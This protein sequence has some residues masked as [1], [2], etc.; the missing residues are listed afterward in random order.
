MAHRQSEPR[1]DDGRDSEAMTPRFGGGSYDT[2]SYGGSYTDSFATH[3][4]SMSDDVGTPPGSGPAGNTGAVAGSGA[5]PYSAFSDAMGGYSTGASGASSFDSYGSYADSGT[6]GR[7]GS[8]LN[9]DM[10]SFTSSTSALSPRDSDAD[11]NPLGHS[12]FFG[13]MAAT[14]QHPHRDSDV[15]TP[16]SA[17]SSSGQQMS[18]PQHAD[19]RSVL[20][21][22]SQQHHHHANVPFSP[23][24][25]LSQQSKLSTL[26]KG[27]TFVTQKA[28]SRESVRELAKTALSVR[29][30]SIGDVTF[31]QPG[32]ANLRESIRRVQVRAYA[33]DSDSLELLLVVCLTPRDVR[34][35]V[36]GVLAPR[37]SDRLRDER[38]DALPPATVRDPY[39]PG[40]HLV[41]PRV[42]LSVG[43]AWVYTC[44]LVG[45]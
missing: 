33:T 16:R 4:S 8:D 32:E 1:D 45:G 38:Q 5:A 26:S 13:A 24:S 34:V 39:G 2:N 23:G 20:S 25:R 41:V 28:L 21:S 7:F 10:N 11:S 9:V 15:G 42:R 6:T 12:T 31:E 18:T 17:G 36:L 3:Y 43:L 30:T 40:R 37:S 29:A 44:G 14:P 35:Y 22:S 19:T 27:S